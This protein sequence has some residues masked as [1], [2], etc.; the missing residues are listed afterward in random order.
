MND[1]P[2][3][4]WDARLRASGLRSTSQRR[5]VLS[6]LADLRHATVDELAAHVQRTNPEVNLSTV[7][8]TLEVLGDVGLVTH[9]HLHHGAPTY[10]VVDDDP[11]LHLVCNECGS[12]QS[13]PV[14]LARALADGAL[15]GTGFQVDLAH[16]VL[17]GRCSGCAATGPDPGRTDARGGPGSSGGAAVF[18]HA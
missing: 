13:Q 5:A 9:A 16:L 12:V 17:H 3:A 18:P 11:H 2:D 15:A 1:D 14:T 7:Y 10:H 4:G 8:R 6:A